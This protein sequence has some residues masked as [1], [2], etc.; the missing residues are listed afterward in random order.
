MAARSWRFPDLCAYA[1]LPPIPRSPE[2]IATRTVNLIDRL[3]TIHPHLATWWLC[4]FKDRIGEGTMTPF[5]VVRP[6]FSAVVERNKSIVE[7]T[8]GRWLQDFDGYFILLTNTCLSEY[9]PQ[10]L[11]V[12]ISTGGSDSNNTVC[13]DTSWGGGGWL[14]RPCCASM[15]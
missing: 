13:A 12:G 7:G 4:E 1:Y 2:V 3:S 9:S 8:G 10:D 5:P 11:G 6:D 14:I 15:S